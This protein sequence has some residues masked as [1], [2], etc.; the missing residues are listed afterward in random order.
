MKSSKLKLFWI[1]LTLNICF[2]RQK[3]IKDS[4]EV[5]IS[6]DK[7]YIHA[8]HHINNIL[9]NNALPISDEEENLLKDLNIKVINNELKVLIPS[10]MESI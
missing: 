4:W 3:T 5:L 7:E 8:S 10:V 6:K 9:R 2:C 1:I